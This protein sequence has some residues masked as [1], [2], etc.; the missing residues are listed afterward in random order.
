ML[1]HIRQSAHE[2]TRCFQQRI[3]CAL[4]GEEPFLKRNSPAFGGI[5]SP[6]R[7]WRLIGRC[8]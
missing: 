4:D 7:Q 3:L 2:P 5:M 8:H 6:P 1:W